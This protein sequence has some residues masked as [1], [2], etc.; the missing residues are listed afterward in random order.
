MPPASN[1]ETPDLF[2]TYHNHHD[3]QTKGAEQQLAEIPQTGQPG[4]HGPTSALYDETSVFTE[5]LGSPSPSEPSVE[6][7]S[8]RSEIQCRDERDTRGWSFRQRFTEL[9]RD[10]FDKS[11]IPAIQAMLIMAS[12]LLT[13]GDERNTSWLYARNAFNMVIDLGLHV[14]GRTS[15]STDSVCAVKRRR[16]EPLKKISDDSAKLQTDLRT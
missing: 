1:I 5:Q 8:P 3:L 9:L 14:E 6:P 7:H 12:S 13:R 16:S 15:L 11:S 10:E 2:T 4:Y